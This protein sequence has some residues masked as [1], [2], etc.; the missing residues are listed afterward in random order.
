MANK[1]PPKKEER[2]ADA[3]S[4]ETPVMAPPAGGKPDQNFFSGF[5][6]V[7]SDSFNHA[8]F[9][10]VKNIGI[11]GPKVESL[12]SLVTRLA[13]LHFV[14]KGKI[15]EDGKVEMMFCSPEPIVTQEVPLQRDP[16]PECSF[17]KPQVQFVEAPR[18]LA[19]K[20][21]HRRHRTLF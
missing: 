5:D 18:A 8:S 20:R 6:F 7:H 14:V 12:E 21:E 17:P 1:R 11:K 9:G 13:E 15:S 4:F 19:A 2:F 3:D 10:G 16:A